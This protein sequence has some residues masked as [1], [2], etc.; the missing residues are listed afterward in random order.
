MP[1]RPRRDVDRRR[2][3]HLQ[4]SGGAE[5]PA[6][7]R[8]GGRRDADGVRHPQSG[9]DD[10]TLAPGAS[11]RQG[12]CSTRSTRRSTG[13]DAANIVVAPVSADA[14]AKAGPAKVVVAARTTAATCR[15]GWPRRSAVSATA[16]ICSTCIRARSSRCPSIR[17]AS[18]RWARPRRRLK[19]SWSSASSGG[20]QVDV[21]A[22]RHAGVRARRDA[23]LANN[24]IDWI[25]R[26]GKTSAPA[27]DKVR[28]GQSA[29]LAGR[30]EDG[31]GH[32]RWQAARHLGVRLGPGHADAT[33]LRRR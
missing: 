10:A 32:L 7:A 33:D 26:D 16:G 3:D 23:D 20:A 12:A 6:H 14:S 1:P 24:P 13:F 27:C 31:H 28:L 8:A 2:H 17:S 21:S 5:R 22:G 15:A 30:P 4:P 25:T 11:R 29:V 19:G 9:S 18:R